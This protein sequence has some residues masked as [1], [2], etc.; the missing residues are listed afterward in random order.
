VIIYIISFR[1]GGMGDGVRDGMVCV[2]LCL[3]I[4]VT[5]T[6]A[7]AYS[8]LCMSI[9]IFPCFLRYIIYIAVDG[10]G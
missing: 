9:D 8:Y 7:Y 10:R 1:G 6:Y 2:V 4:V 3:L 5:Y